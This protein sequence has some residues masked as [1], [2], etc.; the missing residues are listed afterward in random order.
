MVA[1]HSG[2]MSGRQWKRLADRLAPSF[3]VMLPDFLGSGESPP[4]PDPS[5][6]DPSIAPDALFDFHTDVD[7]VS[8]LLASLAKP[9]HLIGHSYGGLIALT[10]AREHHAQ[11]RSLAVYDPV[12]FGVLY[13][14]HDE[15]GL[16]DLG[17]AAEHPVFLDDEQGGN[18]AWFEAFVDYWNGTGAWKALPQPARDSF[19]RVGR[20]VYGEVRSL[21]ND[22]TPKAGYAE[23]TMPALL[24]SGERSPAAARRVEAQL[25]SALPAARLETIAGAG[26]MGPITHAGEVNALIQAHLEAAS[27]E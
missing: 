12:A 4:W 5:A 3:Q 25:A 17:R 22:R 26:H 18:E 21:M 8:A 2:G 23:L 19:L 27:V 24:L 20:K 9:V 1:L 16:A 6:P 13:D 14:A 10:V 7:E 15:E 11:V